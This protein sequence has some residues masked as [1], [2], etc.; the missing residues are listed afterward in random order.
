MKNIIKNSLKNEKNIF[1]GLIIISCLFLFLS[2]NNLS[3][4]FIHFNEDNNALYGNAAAN[5][6]NYGLFNLKLGIVGSYLDKMPDNIFFYTHHPSFFILPTFIIYKIFGITEITTRLIPFL[7]AFLSIFIFF[8]LIKEITKNNIISLISTFIF[9]ISPALTFYGKMLDQEIFILFFALLS[10]LFFLKFKNTSK[11]IYFYNLLISIF[12]GNLCGWHFY[13]IPFI[14]WLIILLD[15]QV[16]KR[17]LLSFLIPA[18]VIL[19]L[20]LIFFHLY[21]LNGIDAIK[22]LFNAFNLRTQG[23]PFNYWIQRIWSILKLN[24]PWPL[25]ILSLF[26]LIFSIFKAVKNKKIS[27]DIILF[28]FPFLITIIFKQWVTHPY[29]PFY[30]LPFIAFSGGCILN[31]IYKSLKKNKEDKEFAIILFIIFLIGQFYLG[32]TG[33][34]FFDKNLILDD[35][36]ITFIKEI[37]N[38]VQQNDICLGKD[39]TGIGYNAIISFYLQKPLDSSPEC[40][41]KEIPYA[42]IF[43]PNLGDFFIAETQ[44]FENAGYQPLQCNGIL[45]FMKKD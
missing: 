23:L 12:F 17:K 3:A 35:S 42:L 34:K 11:K 21:I 44:N 30:F 20:A 28:A 33:L 25:I 8:F 26:W 41:K 45:C 32:F 27:W 37:K 24:F 19:S 38:E 36:T 18:I 7:L 13:F 40:L 31:S 29:G 43:N 1:I 2:T 16:P 14:I 22:D 6:S 5:W 15:K 4:P 9:A 39:P 10:F